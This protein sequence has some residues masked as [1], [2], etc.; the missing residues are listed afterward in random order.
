[1]AYCYKALRAGFRVFDEPGRVTIFKKQKEI[2][3][4][5][6]CNEYHPIRFYSRAPSCENCGSYMNSENNRLAS[7]KCKISE[8][9]IDQ[10]AINIWSIPLI[11]VDLLKNYE[12]LFLWQVGSN[13]NSWLEQR[14][15][16]KERQVQQRVLLSQVVKALN[17][18]TRI[19]K[20]RLS[21][22]R[23]LN[24]C[25]FERCSTRPSILSTVTQILSM[26][27][28][29]GSTIHNIALAQACEPRLCIIIIK[30]LS[31]LGCSKSHPY[32]NCHISFLTSMLDREL[33]YTRERI[34]IIECNLVIPI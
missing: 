11:M 32:F 27:V 9:P 29:R 22:L 3:I 15:Q 28:E 2:D 21:K 5:R 34:S 30:E 8:A 23:K 7:T 18:V 14:R 17:P 25:N 6:R 19:F 4:C 1:M 10:T 26:N 13:I 20:S 12:N 33:Q 24:K 31:R 16:N